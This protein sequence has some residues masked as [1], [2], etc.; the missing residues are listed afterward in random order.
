MTRTHERPDPVRG[1]ND[2]V[3]LFC[4][5]YAGGGVT[6]F[7]Q[8]Q[9][10]A[11]K[12]VAIHPVELPGRGRRAREKP[13]DDY[14]SLVERLAEEIAQTVRQVTT[15]G[16]PTY[17]LYGHSSGG[18]FCFGVAS[19]LE[20][21][22]ILPPSHCFVS[23]IGP[24]HLASAE[25]KRGD[26][27]KEDLAAEL[28]RLGGTPSAVM[29]EPAM[30]EYLLPIIRAD[31]LA[32]EGCGIDAERRIGTPM[33]LFAGKTDNVVRPEAVWEW[34]RYTRAECNKIY[35]EGDHFSV[36]QQPAA[37]LRHIAAKLGARQ[38]V[39]VP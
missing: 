30:L 14:A 7:R 21:M 16:D 5:P 17:A 39:L 28:C 33:T 29:T 15:C 32:S 24:P 9:A 1:S 12:A 4:L 20:S 37:A 27:R 31:F 2:S 25:R 34:D 22:D 10:L 13:L 11:P 36:L 6:S 19:R 35:L 8:W 23:S 18:R 26:L 3:L 38:V